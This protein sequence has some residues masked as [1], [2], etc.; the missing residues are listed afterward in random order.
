MIYGILANTT[1]PINIKYH[2]YGLTTAS[3]LSMFLSYKN[4]LCLLA[5]GI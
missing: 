2:N 1:F 4:S 5:D 3:L